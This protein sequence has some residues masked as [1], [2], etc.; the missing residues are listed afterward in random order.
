MKF[1]G[2]VISRGVFGR[3]K[4]VASEPMDLQILPAPPGVD[5][6]SWLPAS[7][8]TLR[9]QWQTQSYAVVRRLIEPGEAARLRD[10]CEEIL[11]QWRAG[12]DPS[13]CT[14]WAGADP[15]ATDS[16][17]ELGLVHRRPAFDVLLL[18][19]VVELVVGS[20]ALPLVRPQSPAP[21]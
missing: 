19:L 4:R 13:A 3:Y 5:I 11:Q 7:K 12:T 8:V 18:R 9:E 1:E 15:S 21:S 20:A 6:A 14:H 16:P 17:L 10:L 2:D